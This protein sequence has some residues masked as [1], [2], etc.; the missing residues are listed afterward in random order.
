MLIFRLMNL[1]CFSDLWSFT[2]ALFLLFLINVTQGQDQGEDSR[3]ARPEC[4][5]WSKLE[6]KTLPLQDQGHANCTTNPDCTGFSCVGIY[7][8]RK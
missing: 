5:M 7:Q 8:V 2:C 4:Q 1:L 6:N 3:M